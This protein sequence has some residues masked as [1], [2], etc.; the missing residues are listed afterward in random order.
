MFF[1]LNILLQI[2]DVQYIFLNTSMILVSDIFQLVQKYELRL[3][4]GVLSKQC[5]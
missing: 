2:H 3:F 1:S 5:E 4:G